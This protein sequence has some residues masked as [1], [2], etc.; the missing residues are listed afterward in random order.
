M[1]PEHI[2]PVNCSLHW[3]IHVL[4]SSVPAFIQCT[5]GHSDNK[6]MICST[7]FHFV[8]LSSVL[9]VAGFSGLFLFCLSLSS[10]PY[11]TGFSGLSIFDCHY[12]ILQHLFQ[13]FTHY[14]IDYYYQR[15]RQHRVQKTKTNKTKTQHNMCWTLLCTQTQLTKTHI[16][17]GREE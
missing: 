3:Q 6:L 15:N 13:R 10:V 12:G 2:Q 8:S 4:L 7:I 16:S 14:N 5:A 17:C 1:S 9:Y 11:V